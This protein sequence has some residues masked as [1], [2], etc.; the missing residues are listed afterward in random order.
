[1]P[2]G[3]ASFRKGVRHEDQEAARAATSKPAA[4]E[5]EAQLSTAL[6]SGSAFRDLL[7][8]QGPVVPLAQVLRGRPLEY[9]Q[10]ILTEVSLLG[11]K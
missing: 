1:M 6:P 8:R 5:T 10:E 3:A 9:F 4:G 7:G 2:Q 11:D